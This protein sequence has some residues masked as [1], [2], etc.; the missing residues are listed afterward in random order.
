MIILNFKQKINHLIKFDASIPAK[1]K[2]QHIYDT[3]V[4]AYD[5]SSICC[6]DCFNS[7]WSFHASYYRYISL[8]GQKIR[9]KVIR[10]ICTHCH[11][12]HTVLISGMIPFISL[13]Y[14]DFIKVLHNNYDWISSYLKSYYQKKSS[15]IADP[16]YLSICALFSRHLPCLVFST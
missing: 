1:N 14:H 3:F 9:I 10:V 4:L 15:I 2:F 13:F 7:D 12:T 8:F 5:F 16:S 11:K 6:D